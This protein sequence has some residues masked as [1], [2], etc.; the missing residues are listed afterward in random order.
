MREQNNSGNDEKNPFVSVLVPIYKVED[1][2]EECARS[3]FEQ[4]S[5]DFEIIFVDDASPDNSVM[6]VK[7]LLESYPERKPYVR[8]IHNE[9]NYGIGY[10][11][12]VAIEAARGKYVLHS[13][14]DDYMNRDMVEKLTQKAIEDD[15]DVVVCGYE[16][17]N[18]EG[19][20]SSNIPTPCSKIVRISEAIMATG[21]YN[22][23]WNK[24]IRK[25]VYSLPEIMPKEGIDMGEDTYI[26][27]KMMHLVEKI[28]MVPEVLYHYRYERKGSYVTVKNIDAKT[29][30]SYCAVLL[31]MQSYLKR[32]QTYS[33]D[34]I[35]NALLFREKHSLLYITRS[36]SYP[37]LRKY[38]SAFHELTYSEILKDKSSGTGGKTLMLMAK[39]YLSLP[40]PLHLPFGLLLH[41]YHQWHSSSN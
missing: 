30:D 24:L 6:K 16:A 14:S 8:F 7:R 17:F 21:L 41:L 12:K 4:T 35:Q 13:D 33:N 1:Y 31:D 11:R 19:V 28:S 37:C 26:N 23:H 34:K 32:Q 22:V 29:V 36:K 5:T 20:L 9:R 25:S 3:I 27:Y 38:P 39:P 10:T 40:S 18:T 15:A 2:I